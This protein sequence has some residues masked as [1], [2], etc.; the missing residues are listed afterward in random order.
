MLGFLKNL[1]GG[2]ESGGQSEPA[3]GSSIEYQGYDIIA[4]PIKEGGQYRLS[5]I[6][7]KQL[8][9]EIKEHKFIRA[10]LMASQ[11]DVINIAHIKGKQMIDQLG[12]KVFDQ[13]R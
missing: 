7:R 3:E 1:F 13:G 10:D 2:Q 4:T 12:D 8:D 9:E 11:E 6:I 5:G